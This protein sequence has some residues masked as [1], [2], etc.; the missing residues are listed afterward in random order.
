MTD[1]PTAGH[2]AGHTAGP[3]ASHRAEFDRRYDSHLKHL[4]LKGMQP[5]TIEAYSH[6]IRRLG[7]RFAWR[8]DA[9]TDEQLTEHFSQ[10][11]KT[12]SWSSV[13]HD[14]YGYKFYCVHVLG[15][16]WS[17]N[18]GLIKPPKV[19]RLPD[20]VTV[21]EAARLFAATRCLSY[22]VFFFTLYSL[23]LRL[24]EALA[25]QVGDI[26]AARMRVHVRDAKGNRDRLVPLA[27][28][29]LGVLRR[30]WAVHRNARLLF[31][32]RAG[33]PAAAALA[34]RPLDRAGV[35]RALRE[36]VRGMGLKKTSTPTVCVTAMPRT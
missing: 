11:L 18:P 12:H 17:V 1:T 16:P 10:L 9:L 21:D 32:G 23:G 14:L 28:A 24:G 7:E 20:I 8:I 34:R 30:F 35:Q 5:K 25:L 15:R 13:K 2:T 31:P 19:Q 26:D 22:R 33:G 27:E 36:V 4:R 6:G 29:T 3:T